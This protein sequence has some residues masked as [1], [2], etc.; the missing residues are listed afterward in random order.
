MVEGVRRP[1]VS[2][3][4]R[5]SR[6]VRLDAVQVRPWVCERNQGFRGGCRGDLRG[7]V[8]VVDVEEVDLR[9]DGREGEG[10]GGA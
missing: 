9:D 3:R 1:R 7:A 6:F 2:S 4:R 10:E 8:E 5:L